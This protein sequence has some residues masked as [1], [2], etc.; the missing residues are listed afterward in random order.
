MGAPAV[1]AR[2]AD[3][4][5][6]LFAAGAGS[7]LRKRK[8]V[9]I[10][11]DLGVTPAQLA[12]RWVVRAPDV[13]AIP[14]SADLEHVRANRDALSRRARR[15]DAARPRRSISPPT[16]PTPLAMTRP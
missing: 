4:G 13:I 16:G 6:G 10:A 15:G 2:T 8:L 1:A 5:D 12:L 9:A 11:R 7:L 3:P 14:E